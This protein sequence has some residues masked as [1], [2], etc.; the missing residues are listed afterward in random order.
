MLI[1]IWN[2]PLLVL[3]KL[4]ILDDVQ[5]VVGAGEIKQPKPVHST[6][7]VIN[8]YE[9]P[10]YT[11]APIPNISN[12]QQQKQVLQTVTQSA[13]NNPGILEKKSTNPKVEDRGIA[14]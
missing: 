7:L 3:I 9:S 2:F 10:S 5:K 6:Q 11:E 13:P 4:K 8:V 14:K 1:T 12:F